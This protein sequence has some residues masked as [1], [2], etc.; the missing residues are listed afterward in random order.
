[1][2]NRQPI[3]AA[4]PPSFSRRR[5]SRRR[6]AAFLLPVLL[7]GAC[8][9]PAGETASPEPP[10]PFADCAALTAPPGA[11]TPAEAVTPAGAARPGATGTPDGAARAGDGSAGPNGLLPDVS[12][13]DVSL[14]CFTGGATVQLAALRGPAVVNLWAS[15]CPPCRKE[16]PAFQ[17]LADRTGGRLH[18]IGVDVRDRRESARSLAV[19]FGLTFPN[20][21]DTDELLRT[22]LGRA[23]LPVTLLLDTEGRIR[24]IDETGALDDAALAALVE[25]HLGVA[26]SP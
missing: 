11:R 4:H 18:V 20:L 2:T 9:E 13:P 1:M 26:T 17:R 25:R 16:L 23:A 21:V 15:W 19:D 12:L 10:P 24:H 22:R 5:P 14:P 6:I 3:G 8:A 7:A